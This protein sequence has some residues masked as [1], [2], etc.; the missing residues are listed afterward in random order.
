MVFISKSKHYSCTKCP[1]T[2]MDSPMMLGESQTL[3]NAS[4]NFLVGSLEFFLI[5]Q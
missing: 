5:S 1:K 4:I 3:L 2:I